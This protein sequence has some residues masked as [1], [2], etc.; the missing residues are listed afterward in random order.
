MW[1]RQWRLASPGAA[2]RRPRAPTAPRPGPRP[3]AAQGLL[4]AG[5]IFIG[6]GA[7]LFVVFAATMLATAC[8]CRRRALKSDADAERSQLSC[9]RRTL[10]PRCGYLGVVVCL[11]AV[12]LAGL[13][14]VPLLKSGFTAFVGGIVDMAGI[15]LDASDYMGALPT[16]VA[17]LATDANAL[18]VRAAAGRA[19]R[20]P[21]ALYL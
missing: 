13:A 6:L 4:S 15:L 8:F 12:A 17:P 3:P 2:G 7:V 10:G 5:A 20:G 18:V 21:P 19:A 11:V 9:V 16:Y 14:T 1:Y